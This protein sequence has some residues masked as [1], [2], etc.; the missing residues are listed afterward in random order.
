[1]ILLNYMRNTLGAGAFGIVLFAGYFWDSSDRGAADVTVER[2]IVGIQ[3]ANLLKT[4]NAE[5]HSTGQTKSYLIQAGDVQIARRLV[6]SA[7]G[8]VTT[9]LKIIRTVA[10]TLTNEQ[11]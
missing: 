10:A 4:S 5:I 7:G 9:E 8:D 6:E 1:M 11:L 2:G 3:P